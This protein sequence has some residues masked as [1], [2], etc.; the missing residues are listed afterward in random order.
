MSEPSVL[1]ETLPL[2]VATAPT[3]PGEPLAATAQAPRPPALGW[4]R[5]LRSSWPL[6]LGVA[7]LAGILLGYVADEQQPRTYE[8][9]AV[10]QIRP[11]ADD[12][13]LTVAAQVRQLRDLNQQ[14]A[15]W[16]EADAPPFTPGLVVVEDSP[17]VVELRL[18]GPDPEALARQVT[19]VVALHRVEMGTRHRATGVHLQAELARIEAHLQALPAPLVKDNSA[20]LQAA[21][22]AVERAEKHRREIAQTLADATN[23][24][25]DPAPIPP[26]VAEKLLR[27]D[28]RGVQLLNAHTKML[29]DIKV[30]E[31]VSAPAKRAENLRPY[32][33]QLTRIEGQLADLEHHLTQPLREQAKARW[34]AGRGDHRAQL[35]RQLTTARATEAAARAHLEAVAT[36][37]VGVVAQA[38]EERTKL[39][40]RRRQLVAEVR[41]L[42]IDT[43]ASGGF[44]VSSET[45]REASFYTRWVGTL[46]AGLLGGVGFGA[47]VVARQRAVG[48][49]RSATELSATTGL[50]VLAKVP[51]V[52]GDA[53]PI[54]G[55]RGEGSGGQEL[56]RLEAAADQLRG[57][58]LRQ[59][60]PGAVRLLVTSAGPCAGRTTVATQLACSLARGGKRVLLVDAG[61]ERNDLA[62]L[63]QGVPEP[64][65]AEV[66][67]GEVEVG[68]VLQ[69]TNFPRLLLLPAGHPDAQSRAAL[70]QDWAA[71]LFEPLLTE[72]DIVLIDG[73]ALESGPDAAAWAARCEAVLLA[74]RAERTSLASAHAACQRLH[75]LH[76]P[77]LGLVLLENTPS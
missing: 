54:P 5:A 10:V 40:D 64:G 62:W 22:A 59:L 52:S 6:A 17:G 23:E 71:R 70:V 14:P 11:P 28:A 51:L 56:Q 57:P 48:R 31:R 61:G 20:A 1:S 19:Q 43:S 39:E 30:V 50:A 75:L 37:P 25:Y 73:P 36:L 34:E 72:V 33:E 53:L 9:A 7:L 41:A 2:Q 65:L 3:Q 13:H 32:R 24:P 58:V 12:P 38:V 77:V 55:L 16:V 46:L 49:V 8:R 44:H 63:F 60:P 29:A 45:T 42:A 26:A 27:G 67:R 21:R 68:A 47:L 35:E 76:A 69:A 18:R 66:L 4:G 15:R 74:V